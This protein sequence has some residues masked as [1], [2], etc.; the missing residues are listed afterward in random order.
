MKSRWRVKEVV[1]GAEKLSMIVSRRLCGGG[2]P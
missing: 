2:R 1:L